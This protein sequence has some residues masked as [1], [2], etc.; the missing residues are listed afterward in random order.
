MSPVSRIG[1][2][3]IF[4]DLDLESRSGSIVADSCGERVCAVGLSDKKRIK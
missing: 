4:S 1:S 2:G 3:R